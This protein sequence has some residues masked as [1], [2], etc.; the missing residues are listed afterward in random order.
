MVIS[1][2]TV[3]AVISAVIFVFFGIEILILLFVIMSP[4][5][6]STRHH[7]HLQNH[8][9]YYYRHMGD[10]MQRIEQEWLNFL[11]CL[12]QVRLRHGLCTGWLKLFCCLESGG[13]SG[14]E[15]LCISKHQ[16]F[17]E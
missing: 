4:L 7:W 8:Y 3:I 13:S 17:P 9:Y 16:R 6:S 2:I 15:F 10:M 1:A 5:S 11:K 12:Q 14:E